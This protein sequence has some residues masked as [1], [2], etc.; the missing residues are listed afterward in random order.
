M[1][2][3]DLHFHIDR[4]G[5]HVERAPENIGKAQDIVDLVGIVRATGGDDDVLAHFHRIFGRDF[6]VRIGHGENDRIGRHR[7][8]HL[9]R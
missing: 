1:S 8:H 3:G 2:R 5:A 4:L 9:G 6:R 7:A